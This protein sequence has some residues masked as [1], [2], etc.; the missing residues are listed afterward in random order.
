VKALGKDRVW[1]GPSSSLLHVP[2][3]LDNETNE[4][5]LPKE[6][7]NWLAFA[8]QKLSEIKDLAVLAEGE[9]DAATQERFQA[10]KA[11]AESRK[12]SPLIHRSAV[13]DRVNNI[14]DQDAQRTSTFAD[15]KKAQ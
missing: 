2:F 3:D 15:R 13:K 8:K 7:K 5:S 9:V 14:T 11:A 10:N 1:V 6:V 4:E 12:T